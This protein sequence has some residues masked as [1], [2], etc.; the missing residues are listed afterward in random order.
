MN[1]ET[2]SQKTSLGAYLLGLLGAFLIVALLVRLMISYTQAPA[3]SATR[4]AERMQILSDFKTANAPFLDNNK[5]DWQD[6][7][8]GFVRVP[9]ERAK[10]LVLEQWQD[11]LTARSNLMARAALQFA[12]APKPPEKKNEYE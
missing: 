11:P 4:A 1:S 9:I 6:Q 5:Y 7:A 2:C 12:P 10:E 3:I 8:K